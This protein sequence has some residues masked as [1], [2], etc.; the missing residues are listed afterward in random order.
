MRCARCDA[1]LTGGTVTG[2]CPVC[3]IDTALPEQAPPDNG[4]FR[5]DLIEEIG[6]GGM[7]VVY[8]AMQHGSLRQVA[9]KMILAEQAA[10][11][12]MLERFRAEG[13]AIASL[14]HSHI[15]PI[16]E[17]GEI[18][19]TPS[20]IRHRTWRTCAASGQESLGP[21]GVGAAS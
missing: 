4:A 2:L 11:P 21:G 16:Y 13:E 8:R 3:L 19:G 18:D 20:Q 10:T 14:D 9:V 5:Y 15:L 1:E 7:G 6:R 12:G 17:T